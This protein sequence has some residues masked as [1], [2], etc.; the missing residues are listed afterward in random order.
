MT[1]VEATITLRL[2]KAATGLRRRAR[3]AS[4]AGRGGYRGG[5]L[6][7]PRYGKSSAGMERSKLQKLKDF[8]TFPLRAVT[9]IR[10]D[11]LG[12]SSL[13]TE[14]YDYV[15]RYVRGYCLD[16]GC[17]AHNLFVTRWLNGK[18]IN[19]YPYEGLTD[20][21]VVPDM[22]RTLFEDDSFESA[23][24]I[25]ALNHIPRSIRDAELAE[26]YRCLKPSGNIIVTMGNP[27]AEIL[28]HKLVHYQYRLTGTG[29]EDTERG[30]HQ[31]EE[32]YLRDF[33]IVDRLERAGLKDLRRRR[34]VTQW[35]LNHLFVAWKS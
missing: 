17:G 20:E 8:L 31:E 24:L 14:R 3:P 21:N 4:V 35:G 5:V 9:L 1:G 27:L 6:E 13:R 34:F 11:R 28:V 23:T 10:E 30:M 26:A 15:S 7:T 18:G 2:F 29:D 33:E 12:L 16:F 25:A 19:V 32:Y 22:T